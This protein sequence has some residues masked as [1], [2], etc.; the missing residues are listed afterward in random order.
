MPKP[1]DT[2][3]VRSF[4]GLINYYGAFVSEMR[5]LRAPLDA[6]LKKDTSFN[7]NS[8]CNAA[9]ER[10]KEVLAL[11]LL[12]TF[13]NPDLPIVVAADASDYGI[14]QSSSIVTQMDKRKPSITQAALSAPQR[15]TTDK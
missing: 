2:A 14:G 15:R 6:L 10:A 8:K 7:W 4:L 3:Q 1:K 9:F 12:L 11:A 13:Y 5:Q